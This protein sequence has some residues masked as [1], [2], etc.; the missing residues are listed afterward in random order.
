LSEIF[1]HSLRFLHDVNMSDCPVK[2]KMNELLDLVNNIPFR[3][4][5]L[6]GVSD[7]TWIFMLKKHP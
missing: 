5:H 6:D 2:D 3:Q 1:A 4:S 7:Y